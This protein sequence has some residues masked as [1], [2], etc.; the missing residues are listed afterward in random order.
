MHSATFKYFRSHLN[1]GVSCEALISQVLMNIDSQDAR[2]GL[3]EFVANEEALTAAR[4]LD[5]AASFLFMACHLL[6]KTLLMSLGC[7]QNLAAELLLAIWLN[8]M[9]PWSEKLKALVLS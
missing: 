8:Q 2:L 5:E 9:L 1:A 7:Q 3:F 4:A 6:L